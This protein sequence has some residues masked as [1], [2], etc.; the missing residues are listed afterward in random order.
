MQRRIRPGTRAPLGNSAATRSLTVA[1][2]VAVVCGS[3]LA[4]GLLRGAPAEVAP[5]P[6]LRAAV[7]PFT[8]TSSAEPNPYSDGMAASLVLGQASFTSSGTG[9]TATTLDNPTAAAFSPSG[10]LWVLDRIN[11]RVLEYLPPFT[12]GEA[13]SLVLGQATFTSGASGTSAAELDY[14]T[15]LAVS[16]NGTVWVADSDNNRV[17]GFVPPFHDGMDATVVVGQA[18]FLTTASSRTAT[19]LA[20]PQGLGF[21]SSG[22]LFVADSGNDR[23]LAYPPPITSG[24]SA[25]LVFGQ[26]GFDTARGGTTATNLSIPVGVA[27]GPGGELFVGDAANNRVVG[28]LP[29]FSDGE[30]ASLYLGQSGPSGGTPGL[31][32]VNFSDPTFVTVDDRGDLW[33][34]DSAN[35]RVLEFPPPFV[36]GEAASVV[37]GQANFTTSTASTTSQG[38]EFPLGVVQGPEGA[39]WVVDADNNRV[40]AFAPSEFPL[41][42]ATSGLPYGTSWSVTV[43]GGTLTSTSGSLVLSEENGSYAFSA[44]GVGGYVETPGS[45]TLAVNGTGVTVVLEYTATILGMSPT[46]FW[47]LVTGILAAIVAIDT[48]LIVVSLL[49]QRHRRTGGGPPSGAESPTAPPTGGGSPPPT[50]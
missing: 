34:A 44:A 10:A 20:F 41:E 48:G 28:Y 26:S 39:L 17:V 33:V 16:S 25:T 43:A 31:T 45:G 3:A 6:T 1:I 38:V 50:G 15:D 4:L 14:P 36:T 29:P 27:F 5:A 19:G 9:T 30:A 12:S 7:T 32:A 35:Q 2:A 46:A 42:F 11:N 13:A 21:N 18:S 22:Y 49:R 47:S 24:E 37:L 23:V 40:L 8:A